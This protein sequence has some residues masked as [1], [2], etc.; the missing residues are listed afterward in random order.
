MPEADESQETARDGS[1][2][3]YPAEFCR[4]NLP[5]HERHSLAI[6]RLPQLV[7]RSGDWRNHHALAWLRRRLSLPHSFSLPLRLRV[8]ISPPHDIIRARSP[9]PLRFH[10]STLRN[11]HGDL[12]LIVCYRPAASSIFR[13][14]S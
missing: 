12:S 3:G 14:L 1:P 4:G 5:P 11:R 6:R 13:K 2:S 10:L 7:S 8:K 9:Q